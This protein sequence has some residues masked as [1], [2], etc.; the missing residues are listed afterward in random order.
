[1]IDISSGQKLTINFDITFPHVGCSRKVSDLLHLSSIYEF[2]FPTE[3]SLDAT[4]ISGEQ[5]IN[6]E[7]NIYKRRLDNKG[8]PIEL[9]QKD[10]SKKL[11]FNKFKYFKFKIFLKL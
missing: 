6:I 10:N 2:F 8:D 3:L 9:P 11:N 4:D 5:H 7:H 1:M